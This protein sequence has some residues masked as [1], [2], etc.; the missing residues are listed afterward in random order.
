MNRN[1]LWKSNWTHFRYSTDEQLRHI[2]ISRKNNFLSVSFKLLSRSTLTKCYEFN[3]LFH[4][5]SFRHQLYCSFCEVCRHLS[6]LSL[7]FNRRNQVKTYSGFYE[8][9]VLSCSS[10][11]D[12]FDRIVLA[13]TYCLTD[14]GRFTLSLLD[15]SVQFSQ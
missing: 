12:T 6:G 7:V 10:N 5:V 13:T 15:Y 4:F 8:T 11:T 2:D 9:R 14:H 3:V 1:Q